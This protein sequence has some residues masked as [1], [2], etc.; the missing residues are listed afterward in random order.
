MVRLLCII[1]VFWA[2]HVV[3]HALRT[4]PKDL[5]APSFGL[6]RKREDSSKWPFFGTLLHLL[7]ALPNYTLYALV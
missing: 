5:A 2:L 4:N 6:S 7:K 3:T 1:M